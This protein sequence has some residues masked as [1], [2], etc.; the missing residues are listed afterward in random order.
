MKI[1]DSYKLLRRSGW[2]ELL[3]RRDRIRGTNRFD[4]SDEGTQNLDLGPNESNGYYDPI[5]S[6]VD[7]AFY[8]RRVES[9][10]SVI[11][12]GAGKAR[13]MIALAQ[14][15]FGKVDGV[16]GSPELADIGRRNLAR[17]YIGFRSEIFS[18]CPTNFEG[19]D[20]YN[21][22]YFHVPY[23]VGSLSLVLSNIESSIER[24]PRECWLA[25]CS[26]EP[27]TADEM[28]L[29]NGLFERSLTCIADGRRVVTVHQHSA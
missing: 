22:F 15:P 11:N 5:A 18:C 20:A 2:R 17:A 24:R 21:Y 3:I 12:I 19:Y 23:S 27:E 16:E 1:Y 25:Y 26:A 6:G 13:A 28:I 8:Y 10:S 14:F 9:T 29:A 7:S 4:F